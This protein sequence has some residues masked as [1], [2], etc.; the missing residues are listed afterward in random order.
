MRGIVTDAVLGRRDKLGFPNPERDWP[1]SE[2]MRRAG[3]VQ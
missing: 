2:A 1:V 3:V